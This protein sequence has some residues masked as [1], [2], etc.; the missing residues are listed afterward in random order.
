M[1]RTFALWRLADS[2]NS[3][4]G[5]QWGANKGVEVKTFCITVHQ[6]VKCFTSC[7]Q[8]V[9]V[10]WMEECCCWEERRGTDQKGIRKILS[11]DSSRIVRR[12]QEHFPWESQNR[13]LH[14]LLVRHSHLLLQYLINS[15]TMRYHLLCFLRFDCLVRQISNGNELQIRFIQKEVLM[16]ERVR[17]TG[18]NDTGK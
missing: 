17:P 13:R 15:Y 1:T 11:G 5:M 2:F 4:T 12:L 7:A 3:S 8:K 14:A 6:G 18:V 9:C 10:C 16:S